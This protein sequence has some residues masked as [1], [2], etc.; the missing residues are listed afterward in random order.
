LPE[1]ALFKKLQRSRISKAEKL[2]KAIVEARL[3]KTNQK[4]ED[5]RDVK[6]SVK[7]LGEQGILTIVDEW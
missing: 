1:D 5:Y 4:F 2:A 3:K 7:G 6:K